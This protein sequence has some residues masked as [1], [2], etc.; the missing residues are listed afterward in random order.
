MSSDPRPLHRAAIQDWLK[1]GSVDRRLAPNDLGVKSANNQFSLKISSGLNERNEL[2]GSA[3][4]EIQ[5]L[6]QPLVA[7]S[8]S[9]CND[10]SPLFFQTQIEPNPDAPNRPARRSG[11]ICKKRRRRRRRSPE[12]RQA[13][14]AARPSAAAGVSAMITR[15]KLVEQL[16]DYQ[17]RSQ[18]K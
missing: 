8:S 16:R 9:S 6:F 11:R 1:F 10:F 12:G 3:Q 7:S 17:I 15:S 18:H 4:S 13:A 5:N 2:R 14:V